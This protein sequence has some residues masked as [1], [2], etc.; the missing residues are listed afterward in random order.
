[1]TGFLPNGYLVTAEE[2]LRES[3]EIISLRSNLGSMTKNW[4]FQRDRADA[5]ARRAD[6][7]VRAMNNVEGYIR[8]LYSINGEIDE[9]MKEVARLLG[10]EL[11]KSI[12]GRTVVVIDWTATVP[13]DYDDEPEVHIEADISD[14]AFEDFEYD[15]SDVSTTIEEG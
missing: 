9:D 11:T 14:E 8:D 7:L 15:A 4:E 6:N 10:I 5:L 2:R 13:L 1:M 12:S 3:N